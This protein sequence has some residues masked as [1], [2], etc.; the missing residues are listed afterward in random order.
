MGHFPGFFQIRSVVVVLFSVVPNSLCQRT[1]AFISMTMEHLFSP[2]TRLRDRFERRG[3]R[4]PEGLQELNLDV[5]TEALLSAERGFTYVD[6]YAMLG[7]GD[8]IAWLTP[9]AAVANRGHFNE[10]CRY[11]FNVDG[12]EIFAWA[13]SVEAMSEICDVVL[14]LSAVSVVHSVTLINWSGPVFINAPTLAYLMEQCQ[15]LK[16]LTLGGMVLR[17]DHCRVLGAHSRQDL[18]IELIRCE[19]T[20][21]GTSALAEVLGRNQ[22]PTRL[23]S[24]T[25]DCSVLANGLRGNSRLKSLSPKLFIGPGAGN[26]QLFAIADAVRENKGLVELDLMYFP[27]NVNDETWGVLCDSLKTHPTLEVVDLSGAWPMAPDVITSRTQA[28]LEIMKVNTTIQTIHLS[29][30]YR[31]HELFRESVIPYLETNRFRPRRLAIQKIR[32]IAYRKKVLGRALLA[33]RTDPNSFWMLLSGN[34][35]VAFSSTTA[36]TTPAANLPTPATA[37]AIAALG[38]A[39]NPVATGPPAAN[40]AA[41]ASGQKRKTSP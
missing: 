29:D 7:N 20:N 36:T 18:K 19:L 3:L 25:T 22:G 31:Y 33:A 27:F 15:S 9:H 16:A 34:A 37:S 26:R 12:K 10:S 11:H 1:A 6:L 21:G 8:T 39:T 5:S 38:G 32:L 2:C 14:R 35:E 30:R 17:E 23:E 40:I 28:L 13:S 41:P 24:C 4:P